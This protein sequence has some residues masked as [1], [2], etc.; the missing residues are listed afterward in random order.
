[1]KCFTVGVALLFC[2]SN[3]HLANAT[4]IYDF[5]LPENGSVSAFDIQLVFPDLLQPQGLLVIPVT[6]PEVASLTFNTPGFTPGGSVIGLEITPSATLFG[7]ALFNAAAEPL[8]L[9]VAYP[10]DFFLF[11][12][13]PGAT[14]TF[15]SV[16]G[17]V[18]SALPLA[19]STPVGTLSVTTSVPEPST[20]ILGVRSIRCCSISASREKRLAII[21]LEILST[22]LRVRFDHDLVQGPGLLPSRRSSNFRSTLALSS[23]HVRARRS[24]SSGRRTG[25]DH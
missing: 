4:A 18:A 9:T 6:S 23:R 22:A 13:T 21:D 25:R 3:A 19:T 5:S 14:G 20:L 16:A 10:A 17:N 11:N 12:R 8:L 24:S 7:V 1:M 15:S 2:L